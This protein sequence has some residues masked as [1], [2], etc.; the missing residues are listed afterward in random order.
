M[1]REENY[2]RTNYNS[3]NEDEENLEQTEELD[4]IDKQNILLQELSDTEELIRS[5]WDD[6]LE[7]H[8]SDVYNARVLTKLDTYKFDIFYKFML[9]KNV[10][11][12]ELLNNIK[13]NNVEI[14]KFK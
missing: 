5:L 1:S 12:N 6:I 10:Y 13:K 14:D 2:R 7:P 3:D 4:N 8:I 11:L 9:D